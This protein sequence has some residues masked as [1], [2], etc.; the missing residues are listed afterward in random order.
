MHDKFL[1]RRFGWYAL[2]R[3]PVRRL[4][5]AG[6]AM[7]VVA[8]AV[9]GSAAMFGANPVLA[10]AQAA[11]RPTLTAS[12]GA[13]GDGFAN[14]LAISGS[15]AVVGASGK[16]SLTGAAYVF[17]R[18]GSTWS[19]QAELTASDGVAGDYFGYSVAISGSTVVIGAYGKNSGAGAAY[20]FGRSGTTWTQQAEL[21]AADGGAPDFF[22]VSVGISGSTAIVGAYNKNSHV[23]AAEVF[24][25]SG[26]TWTHQ[27]ELT[28]SDGVSPDFFG[29]SVAI[30]GS[31]AVVGTDNAPGGSY[32][33]SAAYVFVRSV[34]TWSQQAEFT[35]SD[36]AAQDGFGL[37]V[38]ISGSTALIGAP[39]KNSGVAY[40]FVRSGT[41]WSQQAELIGSDSSLHNFGVS[42]AISGSTAVVGAPL[43]FLP[44]HRG[45]AYVFVQSGTTWTQLK[46]LS[47]SDGTL[48][49]GF[50]SPVAIS[51]STALVG[52]FSRTSMIG[53]VYI[54]HV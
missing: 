43:P 33:K 2:K 29:F 24:V 23:G 1:P 54:F 15:T 45:A 6:I 35:A 32:G 22:G 49:Q 25:G 51:G 26:T 31:T 8:P 16:N 44:Q 19:Q 12:D 47:A 34:T 30:S 4:G 21:T 5:S 20:V 14:S 17:T 37:A 28:A 52:H 13:A 53:A 9:A 50:G 42:V 27:A 48:H 7:M 18:T 38:A 39:G 3:I 11:V 41:S 40:A 46:I 10:A 36:G